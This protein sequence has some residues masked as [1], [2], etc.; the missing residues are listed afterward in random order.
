MVRACSLVR[1][2][3]IRLLIQ[4]ATTRVPPW[5]AGFIFASDIATHSLSQTGLT[6]KK[7]HVFLMDAEASTVRQT[8]TPAKVGLFVQWWRKWPCMGH[9]LSLFLANWSH[10]TFD[11]L[12]GLRT[13]FCLTALTFFQGMVLLFPSSQLTPATPSRPLQLNCFN[14]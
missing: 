10:W 3:R 12:L 9:D 2:T 13:D 4:S 5:I 14:C 6:G 11:L 1:S 7:G 8:V